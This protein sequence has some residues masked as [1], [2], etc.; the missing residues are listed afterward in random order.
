LD[1]ALRLRI[2]GLEE[3]PTDPQLAAEGGK[4]VGRAAAAG[5]Q[6]ALT[7]P[8]ERLGQRA[9]LRQATA[10]PAQQVGRLLREHQR[11][12]A[13]ARVGQAADHDVAAPRLAAADRDLTRRLPEIE[14]A[15]CAGPIRGALE[16]A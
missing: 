15:E 6:R 9:E 8:D 3:T 5:V 12:S 7:V 10:D 4:R 11:T 13:G 1:H 16:G 14:L 2:P